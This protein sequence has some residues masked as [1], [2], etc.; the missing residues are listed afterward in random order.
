MLRICNFSPNQGWKRINQFYCKKNNCILMIPCDVLFG[1]RWFAERKFCKLAQVNRPRRNIIWIP[2]NK[3]TNTNRSDYCSLAQPCC[4]M[5]GKPLTPHQVHENAK[6]TF[7]EVSALCLVSRQHNSILPCAL[8]DLSDTQELILNAV[9]R[10][11]FAGLGHFPNC[12]V[13]L[14]FW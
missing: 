10:P 12:H 3:N 5:P 14:L 2:Q 6:E 9:S 1:N 13:A 7:G 8:G 11:S 4:T